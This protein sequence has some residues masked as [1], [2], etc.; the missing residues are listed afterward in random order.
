M[1]SHLIQ[2][3]T[4]NWKFY[5]LVFI[6][7]EIML[8][9][10]LRYHYEEQVKNVSHQYINNLRS[11]YQIVLNTLGLVSQTIFDEAINQAELVELMRQVNQAA[12]EQQEILRQKLYQK[13]QPTYEHLKKQKLK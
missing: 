13:L 2:P 10:G 9:F 12:P 8:F 5:I 11:T 6:T 4:I 3:K 1:K 7:L